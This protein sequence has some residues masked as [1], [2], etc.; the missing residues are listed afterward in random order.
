M[1]WIKERLEALVQ[2]RC[3]ELNGQW[4]AFIAAVH[5]R[6]KAEATQS[7]RRSRLQS[8]S[9]APLPEVVKLPRAT[10]TDAGSEAA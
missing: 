2:L 3:I 9:P 4:D 10:R 6:L 1:R 5:D 7:G 8:K